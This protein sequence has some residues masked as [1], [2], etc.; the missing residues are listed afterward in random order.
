MN[1]NKTMTKCIIVKLL[2]TN[3]KG[4]WGE[5]VLEKAL[6]TGKHDSNGS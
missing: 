4:G 6:P 3:N 5:G 2:K 1:A